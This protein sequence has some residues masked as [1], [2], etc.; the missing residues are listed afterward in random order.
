MSWDIY[1]AHV[2]VSL[3]TGGSEARQKGKLWL[4]MN[5][6]PANKVIPSDAQALWEAAVLQPK[7]QDS[8]PQGWMQQAAKSLSADLEVV[9]EPGR[10]PGHV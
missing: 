2:M 3:I 1:M 5:N 10:L 6:C 4:Q 7:P 8:F 9:K